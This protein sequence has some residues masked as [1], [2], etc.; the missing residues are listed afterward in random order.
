MQADQIESLKKDKEFYIG[1]YHVAM[2]RVDKVEVIAPLDP[3]PLDDLE[4]WKPLREAK[5]LPSKR[6][7]RLEK[8]F[9]D[10]ANSK[11]EVKMTMEAEAE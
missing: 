9:R 3:T 5:E 11:K 10:I 1:L 2:N 6:R 7:A 8:K 4:H